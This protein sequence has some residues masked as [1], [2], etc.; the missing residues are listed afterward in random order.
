M[1]QANCLEQCYLYFIDDSRFLNSF[2]VWKFES[3]DNELYDNQLKQRT[4]NKATSWFCEKTSTTSSKHTISVCNTSKFC[5]QSIKGVSVIHFYYTITNKK[6][7]RQWN[8]QDNILTTWKRKWA[9]LI[10]RLEYSCNEIA[11]VLE[12]ISV[13]NDKMQI[14][15]PFWFFV[16]LTDRIPF[17]FSQVCQVH[18]F[19]PIVAV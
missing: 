5:F 19:C 6:S 16:S 8:A 7:P 17:V 9:N 3:F 4:E 11:H 18:R 15:K 14:I 12:H 10:G 1:W 13:F 2:L